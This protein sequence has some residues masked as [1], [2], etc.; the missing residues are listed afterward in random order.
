[1]SLKVFKEDETTQFVDQEEN[2]FWQFYFENRENG[3]LI[4]LK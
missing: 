3:T 4:F 1:M 2:Y